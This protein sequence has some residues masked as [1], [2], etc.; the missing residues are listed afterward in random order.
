MRDFFSD[1]PVEPA[2][3]LV[4]CP[5]TQHRDPDYMLELTLTAAAAEFESGS[6]SWWELVRMRAVVGV[7]QLVWL[8]PF[9][10]AWWLG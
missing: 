6:S 8:C 7:D 2:P 9:C 1:E 3:G 10:G 5:D 4:V